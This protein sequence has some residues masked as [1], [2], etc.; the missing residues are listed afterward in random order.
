M[1]T[2]SA[3]RKHV[4]KR[5]TRLSH[6]L[7]HIACRH[8]HSHINFEPSV[9]KQSKLWRRASSGD[10]VQDHRQSEQ[11]RHHVKQRTSSNLVRPQPPVLRSLH[12]QTAKGSEAKE[13]RWVKRNQMQPNLCM[14]LAKE[15]W[16]LVKCWTQNIY[17]VPQEILE[18]Y[19]EIATLL[20]ILSRNVQI[21]SLCACDS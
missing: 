8:F 3:C 1:E 13:D 12:W 18:G 16:S 11:F 14:Q 2:C 9:G 15:P 20:S 7:S 10:G 21:G 6:V 4:Q 5:Q 19:R 17:L